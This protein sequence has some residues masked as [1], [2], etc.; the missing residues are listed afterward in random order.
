MS[1]VDLH[2]ADSAFCSAFLFS[3]KC[4]RTHTVGLVVGVQNSTFFRRPTACTSGSR[5]VDLQ[6]TDVQCHVNDQ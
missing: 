1:A 3:V 2:E 6:L 5:I 4:C